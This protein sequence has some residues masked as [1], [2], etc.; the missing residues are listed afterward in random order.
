MYVVSFEPQSSGKLES[1][2]KSQPAPTVGEIFNRF[3]EVA[4]NEQF[5]NHGWISRWFQL[6]NDLGGIH[7]LDVVLHFM[8]SYIVR[9]TVLYFI[10]YTL[11]SSRSSITI[12]N[13]LYSSCIHIAKSSRPRESMMEPLDT[14]LT[15]HWFLWLCH[16]WIQVDL[17]ITGRVKH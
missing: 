3:W 4:K 10:T 17:A 16:P 13:K 14:L 15:H 1:V 11:K 6:G 5:F 8:T 12:M 2:T 9:I 7:W